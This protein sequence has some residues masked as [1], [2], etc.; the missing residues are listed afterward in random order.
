LSWAGDGGTAGTASLYQA[1][2]IV[3]GT[4]MRRKHPAKAAARSDQ[5]ATA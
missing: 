4:D 5:A 3:T 1:Y 2:E